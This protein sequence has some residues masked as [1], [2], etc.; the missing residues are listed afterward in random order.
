MPYAQEFAGHLPRNAQHRGIMGGR[1]RGRCIEDPWPRHNAINPWS[2]CGFGITV[3]HIGR[4]LFMPCNDKPNVF[5]AL[6]ECVEKCV[7]LST[8]YAE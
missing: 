4:T 7:G 3:R 8:G 1:Q 5:L 2:A 6:G